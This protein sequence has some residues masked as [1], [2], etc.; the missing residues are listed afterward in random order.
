L[1]VLSPQ[2][3]PAYY[4]RYV[5]VSYFS[6]NYICYFTWLYLL[7]LRLSRSRQ[8]SD[9]NIK[10]TYYHA[11][12]L[13]KFLIWVTIYSILV[14]IKEILITLSNDGR[15]RIKSKLDGFEKLG[16]ES[17]QL[18]EFCCRYLIL[19]KSSGG[20]IFIWYSSI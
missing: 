13:I 11:K 16:Q 5:S 12:C 15:I 10:N 1:L 9:I 2:A 4:H 20:Y 6:Y 17:R 19:S 18:S 14:K 8:Y 3:Q 7:L